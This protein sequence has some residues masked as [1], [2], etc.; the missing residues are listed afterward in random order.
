MDIWL[1]LKGDADL[2]LIDD[3]ARGARELRNTLGQVLFTLPRL[4]APEAEAAQREPGVRFVRPRLGFAER[5]PRVYRHVTESTLLGQFAYQDAWRMS[6]TSLKNLCIDMGDIFRR[7]EP[8]KVNADTI[9]GHEIRNLLT[10]ACMEV[11]SSWRAVLKVNHY[12]PPGLRPGSAPRYTTNDYVKLLAPLRL[13]EYTVRLSGHPNI[14]PF[15][16]FAGWD[17]A[18]PTESLPWY[19]A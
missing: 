13:G 14:D 9:Y 15:A 7:V 10:L 5:H 16:P 3:D 19:D 8:D 17:P 18:R 11:E 1:G 6:R 2:W 12:T 4:D